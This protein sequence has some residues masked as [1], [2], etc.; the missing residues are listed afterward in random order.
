MDHFSLRL[1]NVAYVKSSKDLLVASVHQLVE[2]SLTAALAW[3]QSA[4]KSAKRVFEVLWLGVLK[5]FHQVRSLQLPLKFHIVL[6]P[7]S[8]P[9]DLVEVR[10]RFILE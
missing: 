5:Y 4:V 1:Q 7:G 8:L 6:S 9:P 2:Q 10:H 3:E